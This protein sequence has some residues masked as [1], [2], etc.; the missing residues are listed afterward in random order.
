MEDLAIQFIN[1]E[2]SMCTPL[3]I[4][5]EQNP[6]FPLIS[7][8][9]DD[10]PTWMHLKHTMYYSLGLLSLTNLSK[11]TIA[12]TCSPLTTRMCTCCVFKCIIHN[13]EN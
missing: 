3:C 13:Y 11:I 6:R 7:S 12:I 2:L 5:Q 8:K 4:L 9:F 1:L 10:V